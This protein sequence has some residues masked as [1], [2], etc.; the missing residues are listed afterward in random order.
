M[1]GKR[2][3]LQKEGGIVKGLLYKEFFL[4]RGGLIFGV[5]FQTILSGVCISF[6]LIGFDT[7]MIILLT[8]VCYYLSFL[9]LALVN[10][11]LFTHDERRLWSAFVSST[12]Q[13]ASGQVACKYYMILIENLVLLF[14][15]YLTDVIVLCVADDV[16]VSAI[17]V[18]LFIFCLRILIHAVE[19]PFIIRF[20]SN[21]GVAVK[22]V[23]LA[24]LVLI[25]LC[26]GLFGDISFLFG[27]DPIAAVYKFV[28]GG[29]VVWIAALIPYVA[30]GAYYL[31]YCISVRWY[32]EADYRE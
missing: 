21:V 10:Q 26:Y 25:L 9:I 14:F 22:S 30:A 24:F 6:P 2:C 18:G 16:M 31:S 12:P 4:L 3:A 23:L 15:C 13:A 11:E 8:S 19:I 32:K 5:M 29:K 1:R 27:D 28:T 20:G 17:T 7:K